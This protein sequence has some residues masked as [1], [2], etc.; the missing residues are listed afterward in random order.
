LLKASTMMRGTLFGLAV[1]T[2]ALVAC[3]GADES[4]ETEGQGGAV[5]L[6]ACVATLECAPPAAPA[7]A[8][9]PWRNTAKSK[10]IIAAGAPNHRGRDLFVNPGAPQNVIAQFA[11]GIPSIDLVDEEIDVFV[12]A[13]CA[14]GWEKLGTTVT[15]S[16]ETNHPAVEGVG[17]HGG[18]V[19][20][21]IPAEKRLGPGLHRIRLVVA[22]DGTSTDLLMDVVP[23][24]T[25]VFIADVD[26]TLTSSE[27]VE[28]A[29][30]L[31]GTTP[32]AH[33][34]AP[35]ALRTLTSKGFH[36]VYVTARPEWLTGRTREFLA[37]HGFPLGVVHTSLS[38]IGAGFGAAATEYKQGELADLARKGLAPRWGFGNKTSDSDAYA[39]AIAASQQRIFF[40]IDG[41]FSGRR[42]QSYAEVLPE[43][44][45]LERTCQ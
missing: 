1:I 31:T 28:Y 20:F 40:Q 41:T 27:T 8:L 35:E 38:P 24:E 45:R 25:P 21:E 11:Y 13:D 2:S 19:Y 15:T 12:Q 23:R 36:P 9:R 32:D 10:A 3:S 42:I 26:G 7:S 29:A 43:L 5:G 6:P 44:S 39:G 4:E 18:R 37:T 17:D 14:H 34:K 33:P 30:L 16:S 22:A